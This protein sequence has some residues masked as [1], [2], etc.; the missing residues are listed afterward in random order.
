MH[1][2]KGKVGLEAPL[3]GMDVFRF[4]Y[5]DSFQTARDTPLFIGF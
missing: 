3:K 5:T 4:S 1:K 2:E